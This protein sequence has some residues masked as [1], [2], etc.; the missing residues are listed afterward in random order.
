M[1]NSTKSNRFVNGAIGVGA[2]WATYK[3]LPKVISKPYGRYF[4][5]EVKSIPGN[6]QQ[7]YWEAG[8]KAFINSGLSQKGINIVDINSKN[9]KTVISDTI[10]KAENFT[11]NIYKK[12][13]IDISVIKNKEKTR[14]KWKYILFGESSKDKLTNA[15]CQI[16]KGNSAGFHPASKSVYVNKEKMGFSVFHEM[17]HAVNATEKGIRK[18]LSYG[19]QGTALL[20]PILLVAALLKKRQ[21]ESDAEPKKVQRKK[22]FLKDNIGI[23]SFACMLPTV[24]EEGLASINGAKLAKNVMNV[25]MYKKL[26]KINAKAFGSYAILAALIGIFTQLAVNIKD[27]VAA[28]KN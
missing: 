12:L 7:Q 3:Y 26:N 18:V 20:V 19:R 25:D 13:G 8:Q 10:T 1:T 2:G 15:L 27:K 21:P 16:Y 5:G 9:V 28:P 4:M 14:A 24:A 17:G 11:Q 22:N 6:M 23:L